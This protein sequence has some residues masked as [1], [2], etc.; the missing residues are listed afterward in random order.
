MIEFPIIIITINAVGAVAVLL[1]AGLSSRRQL[2]SELVSA[3]R[4]AQI[5]SDT[6]TMDPVTKEQ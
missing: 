1:W 6:S 4:R 5:Q 3:R 2:R